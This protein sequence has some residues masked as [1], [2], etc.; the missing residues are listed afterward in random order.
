MI[1]AK[2]CCPAGRGRHDRRV[3]GRI[4]RGRFEIGAW[5]SGNPGGRAGVG[6][7]VAACDR[8]DC[9]PPGRAASLTVSARSTIRA[10]YAVRHDRSNRINTLP[11][12]QLPRAS[13]TNSG[14]GGRGPVV[15][16]V[17]NHVHA[18]FARAQ[19]CPRPRWADPRRRRLAI[20]GPLAQRS[21]S[22]GSAVVTCFHG[23]VRGGFRQPRYPR[24][25]LSGRRQATQRLPPPTIARPIPERSP[26]PRRPTICRRTARR[27][28][29]R[30]PGRRPDRR[31][32]AVV[33]G[34]AAYG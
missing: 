5:A 27:R 4:G 25:A 7:R 21:S 34:R 16:R 15:K 11:L 24:L 17:G 14:P 33:P 32:R 22:G 9:H 12:Y 8:G 10:A 30:W 19:R 13:S 26:P 31:P 28:S 6:R 3:H 23:T 2:R 18:H 1:A 20:L 29:G